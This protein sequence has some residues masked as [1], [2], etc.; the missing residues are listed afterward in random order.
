VRGATRDRVRPRNDPQ[1]SK[2]AQQR[3][4][5]PSPTPSRDQFRVQVL[6]ESTSTNEAK[7]S[8]PISTGN[9]V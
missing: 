7:N 4:D 2:R 1:T 8:S 5:P 6:D 3:R 9:P